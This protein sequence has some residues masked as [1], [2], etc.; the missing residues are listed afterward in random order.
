MFDST[1]SKFEVRRILAPPF[2]EVL[3]AF[4][5]LTGLRKLEDC[6]VVVD[7][8]GDVF[9]FARVLPMAF[10]GFLQRE[11]VERRLAPC[12]KCADAIPA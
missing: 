7:L 3:D 9:V 4:E 5:T 10:E 2:P 8:V 1:D 11:F 12:S 6:V